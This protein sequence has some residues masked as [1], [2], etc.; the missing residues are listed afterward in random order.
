MASISD[1]VTKVT[2]SQTMPAECF[3]VER[4]SALRSVALHGLAIDRRKRSPGRH[5]DPFVTD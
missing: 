1:Q 5:W 4:S 3:V 2:D